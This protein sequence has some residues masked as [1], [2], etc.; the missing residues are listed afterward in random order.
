MTPS[1]CTH[2]S[3]PLPAPPIDEGVYWCTDCLM[4]AID[5]EIERRILAFQ[6]RKG[7]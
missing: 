5:H 1:R 2:C 4:E 3:T 6:R 7:R